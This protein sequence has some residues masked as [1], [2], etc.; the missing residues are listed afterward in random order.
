MASWAELAKALAHEV[1][2]SLRKAE[3]ILRRALRMIE[4]EDE[5]ETNRRIFLTRS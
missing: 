3:P 2:P 4:I 5:S 1:L